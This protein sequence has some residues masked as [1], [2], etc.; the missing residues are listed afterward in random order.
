MTTPED[1]AHLKQLLEK[2]KVIWVS[3]NRPHPG[4]TH[5]NLAHT[6]F[7]SLPAPPHPG[8]PEPVIIK[9]L[10]CK[11]PPLSTRR[12]KI[13]LALLLASTAIALTDH[14][15][16]ILAWASFV[17]SL[18]VL[19]EALYR[20]TREPPCPRRIHTIPTEY[21]ELI[22]TAAKLLTTCTATGKC[23]A[24][25]TIAGKHYKARAFR[26]TL[27]TRIY[28]LH[29]TVIFTLTTPKKNK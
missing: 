12:A 8:T 23:E 1:E 3:F 26:N 5:D 15:Y 2:A 18:T 25:V 9:T 29:D 28:N 17:T 7:I 10:S 21:R 14:P 24:E 22:E 13:F 4:L 19:L 27:L 11:P 20:R 16:S 6:L